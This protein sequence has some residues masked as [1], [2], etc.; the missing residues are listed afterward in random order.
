[1]KNQK[2][3]T[4][5]ELLIVVAI[6]GILLIPISGSLFSTMRSF[7]YQSDQVDFTNEARN[8]FEYLNESIR[9]NDADDISVSGNSIIIKNYTFKQEGDTLVRVTS[10]DSI[11]I[12][13][14]V[15]DFVI[16]STG[17]PL[18][19]IDISISFDKEGH[20]PLDID[21]KLYLRT[22]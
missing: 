10:S 11:I 5:V 15:D 6:M 19:S 7:E 12:A 21:T 1:M 22:R 13:K 3:V 4:L 9:R 14:N 20:R 8:A 16:T 17:D 18:K 2:G